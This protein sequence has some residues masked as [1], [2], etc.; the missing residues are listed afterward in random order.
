MRASSL[1]LSFL[2]LSSSF[3]TIISASFELPLQPAVTALLELAQNFVPYDILAPANKM[4][5]TIKV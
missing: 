4:N 3:L 1:I 2:L 5:D